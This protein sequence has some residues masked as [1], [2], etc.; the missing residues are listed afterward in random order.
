MCGVGSPFADDLERESHRQNPRGTPCYAG[1]ESTTRC[2][3]AAK[4]ASR[5]REGWVQGFKKRGHAPR[6]VQSR[7]P[8]W[9]YGRSPPRAPQLSSLIVDPYAMPRGMEGP[10]DG[11][12]DRHTPTLGLARGVSGGLQ[13]TGCKQHAQ[14]HH[15]GCFTA[16]SAVGAKDAGDRGHG[17]VTICVSRDDQVLR[18]RGVG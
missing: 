13:E 11:G 3:S 1:A 12:R 15:H 8:A 17:R 10:K 16:H 7:R 18:V 9:R 14:G 4:P 6:P 2:R 5:Q